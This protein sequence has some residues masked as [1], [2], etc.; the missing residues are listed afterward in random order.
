MTV[1]KLNLMIDDMVYGYETIFASFGNITTM[2]GPDIDNHALL[3][4]KTDVLI[5]RSRTK[6]SQTLLDNTS[7]KF[8]GSTVAGL[9][10]IDLAYLA[11]NNIQFAHAGGSNANAVAEYV[12]SALVNLAHDKNFDLSQKTLGIVGVG[13]VGSC[14]KVKAKKL[15]ITPLL[16]DPLRQAEE[17]LSHFVDLETIFK[18]AD[19]I[20]F[21]TPLT[22]P[23]VNG[24]TSDIKHPSYHLLNANNAHLISPDTI[25]INTARGG[26]ID[27]AVWQN[28]PT[29]ANVI[30][31]WENEPNINHN[32]KKNA[33]WA[34]PHIAGH[35]IDAK[36]MGSFMIYRQLCESLNTPITP[37]VAN[38][39]NPSKTQ[40]TTDNLPDTLNAIYDFTKDRACLD[41]IKAFEDYR[42]YYPVRYEWQHFEHTLLNDILNG[43]D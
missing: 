20:S 40:L 36:F 9:D 24:S 39:I 31:C 4:H 27:E 7:V 42:R 10:H 38:L 19:I 1:P 14:L 35:S 11:Q 6:V 13:N 33:Y 26:V 17:G 18:K 22:L 32:L 21:H 37:S 43:I 28:I 8:V 16:N 34:T 3:K 23:N 30:D 29:L 41:N 15:N 12:I 25:V 5:I 2:A